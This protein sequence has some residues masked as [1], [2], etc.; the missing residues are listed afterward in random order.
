[1]GTTT[2]SSTSTSKPARQ[3]GHQPRQPRYIGRHPRKV[4]ATQ[5]TLFAIKGRELTVAERGA[6]RALCNPIS[7]E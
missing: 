2:T 3:S 7:R 6:A 1:M 4:R 5:H